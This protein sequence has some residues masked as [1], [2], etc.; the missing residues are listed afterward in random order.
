[1]S[2][3]LV[4]RL[5]PDEQI[6]R[7][8]E[9]PDEYQAFVFS[10]MLDEEIS[11][12]LGS[13]WQGL[14]YLFTGT[15]RGGDPHAGF[16]LSEVRVLGESNVVGEVDRT[17]SSAEV[18][19]HHVR[20]NTEASAIRTTPLTQQAPAGLSNPAAFATSD[21]DVPIRFELTAIGWV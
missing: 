7:W 15:E 8:I 20:I 21:A 13:S 3:T 4:L 14:H 1:M 12:D 6:A 5:V 16:L 2:T 11:L 17:L 18:T 19:A 10:G 9:K